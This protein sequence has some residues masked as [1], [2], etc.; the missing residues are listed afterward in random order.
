MQK[1]TGSRVYVKNAE[2]NVQRQAK[3]G[4]NRKEKFR[5]V[6][7]EYAPILYKIRP[8]AAGDFYNHSTIW[9]FCIVEKASVYF[10]R[11]KATGKPWS[12]K[13]SSF[14]KRLPAVAA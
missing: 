1:E 5:P 14:A 2:I 12:L 7:W 3:N 10:T 8:P 9:R 11:G 4:A 6:H 13:I